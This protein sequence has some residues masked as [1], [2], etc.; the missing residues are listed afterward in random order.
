M[1]Q[2]LW[3]FVLGSAAL[4]LDAYVIA[5]LLPAI[6]SDLGASASDVGLG[7]AVFTGAYAL[8]G[9]LLAGYAGQKPRVSLLVTLLIFTLANA[10]TAL[11]PNIQVFIAA[12]I[13]AGAAAG[14]FF[15][16]S[17]ASAAN[18]VADNQRGRALALVLAGLAIG[19]V[20]GVPLGLSISSHWGWRTTMAF[21]VAIGFM[22]LTGI[23]VSKKS[24]PPVPSPSALGRMRTLTR[25]ENLLTVSVTLLT[26][27]ASLGLYTYLSPVLASG[28]LAGHPTW[29]IWIWGF[30]GTLGALLIG[31][32]VDKLNPLRLSTIILAGLSLALLGMSLTSLGWLSMFCLFVWGACGWASLTPQQQV[33]ISTNP[34]DGATAVAT[35][36]S[37]NYLGS[38]L[39]AIGGSLLLSLGNSPST[40]TIWAA[41]VALAALATQIL[42]IKL[43]R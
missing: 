34:Q 5:G 19:T 37:A 31:K 38:A 15:P 35:N 30:G 13:V 25:K 6:A 7:V 11:S 21:V 29:G 43:A 41:I 10:A 36:A 9:P 24:L 33:L 32:V 40:L 3:P 18:I 4:G 23:L 26:G 17:S 42:R 20:F 2:I 8:S 28:K 39:G 16:L 12:R 27:I 22:A 1:K 14:I